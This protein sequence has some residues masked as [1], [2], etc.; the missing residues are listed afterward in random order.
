MSDDLKRLADWFEYYK[1]GP[2]THNN[3]Y[4]TIYKNNTFQEDFASLLDSNRAMAA[5]IERGAPFVRHYLATH[6]EAATR[7]RV[8]KCLCAPCGIGNNLLE[9]AD[10]AAQ[11]KG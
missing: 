4:G 11:R 5:R 6:Q 2:E 9:A 3:P 10:A 1:Y 7:R 8:A